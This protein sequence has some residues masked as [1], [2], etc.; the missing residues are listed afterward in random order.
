MKHL[1]EFLILTSLLAACAPE[2]NAAPPALP[3]G[4]GWARD[5]WSAT[6]EANE[7]T[8]NRR[9]EIDPDLGSFLR[10]S[11]SL[12]SASLEATLLAAGASEAECRSSDS[13]DGLAVS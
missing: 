2:G 4:F 1:L 12:A 10:G 11:S 6:V 7:V 5:E 8:V 3:P 13:F 9:V